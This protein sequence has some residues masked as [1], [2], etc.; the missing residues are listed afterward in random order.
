MIEFIQ[1]QQVVGDGELAAIGDLLPLTARTPKF[2]IRVPT[3]VCKLCSDTSQLLCP[4]DYARKYHICVQPTSK[5]F[6][7]LVAP[8]EG[9][10]N[11]SDSDNGGDDGGGEHD[12]DDGDDEGRILVWFVFA[13][14]LCVTKHEERR[15]IILRS[16]R[17]NAADVFMTMVAYGSLH[18]TRSRKFY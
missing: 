12:G 10:A 17:A 9:Q 2:L 6:A 13:T 8:E 11:G 3:Q 4:G 1:Q 16:L 18:D 5:E 15:L 7:N 14:R